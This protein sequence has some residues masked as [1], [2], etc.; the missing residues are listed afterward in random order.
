MWIMSCPYDTPVHQS[1][2]TQIHTPKSSHHHI[3]LPI[4]RPAL[5]LSTP[6]L[7]LPSSLRAFLVA[8]HFAY[9]TTPLSPILF[10]SF[11]HSYFHKTM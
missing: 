10:H 1:V 7:P 11:R 3:Y 9:L 8:C 2:D 6:S 4:P 5:H